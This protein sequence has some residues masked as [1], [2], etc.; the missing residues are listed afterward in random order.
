M[1]CFPPLVPLQSPALPC[2]H[3]GHWLSLPTPGVWPPGQA[4]RRGTWGPLRSAD[5][6]RGS[7]ASCGVA[8]GTGS[9]APEGVVGR[10]RKWNV[11]RSPGLCC[12]PCRAYHPVFKLASSRLLPVSATPVT[13]TSSSSECWAAS[14]RV[15]LLQAV[16]TE[17][18]ADS[19]EWCPLEGCRHLLVCG[20]YQLQKPDDQP[21]DPVSK[22]RGL[23]R[24]RAGL[25][26]PGGISRT[27][28]APGWKSSLKKGKKR[29]LR[30]RTDHKR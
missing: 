23:R 20:T 21:A 5:R 16:D 11:P 7:P 24:G 29:F 6:G 2:L 1:L 25:P 4:A 9:P 10:R 18:T 27:A 26:P 3:A 14:S 17:Y 22:V 12:L 28:E 13:A 8:T 19:V 30:G 15:R